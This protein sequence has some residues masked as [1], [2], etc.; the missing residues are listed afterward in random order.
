MEILDRRLLLDNVAGDRELLAEIVS[1]FFETSR[2]ILAA[3]HEAVGSGD[4]ESI[5]RK[6]HQLKGTLANLGAK[7][8]AESACRLE[9]TGRDGRLDGAPNAVRQLE[10]EMRRL[11]PE[12]ASLVDSRSE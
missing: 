4:A 7:A 1:L 12:L 3:L 11:E 6:A 2:D 9:A 8:A 10:E 5:H